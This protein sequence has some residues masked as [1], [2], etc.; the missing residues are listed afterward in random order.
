MLDKAISNI[1]QYSKN[2]ISSTNSSKVDCSLY[3]E[4]F[5]QRGNK[6]GKFLHMKLLLHFS[7]EM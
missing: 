3:E 2:Q 1:A 7:T 6:Q 4:K 5:Y